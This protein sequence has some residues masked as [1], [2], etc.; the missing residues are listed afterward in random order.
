MLLCLIEPIHAHLHNIHV[1]FQYNRENCSL[2]L[3][4]SCDAKIKPLSYI[5][6]IIFIVRL[7]FKSFKNLSTDYKCLFTF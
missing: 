2:R 7:Y 6:L 4:A 1:F 5:L 3:Y